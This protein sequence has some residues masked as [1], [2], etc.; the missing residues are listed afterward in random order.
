METAADTG[1]I[2]VDTGKPAVDTGEIGGLQE[3]ARISNADA[4]LI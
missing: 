3:I 2:A 4:G 1:K